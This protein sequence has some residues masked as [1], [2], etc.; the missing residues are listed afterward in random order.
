MNGIDTGSV[1]TQ[2][3]KVL[4]GWAFLT[5]DSLAASC[6][7]FMKTDKSFDANWAWQITRDLFPKYVVCGVAVQ[8]AT[9]GTA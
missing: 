4:L 3:K 7:V 1:T 9:G 5:K 2:M 6:F 8:K